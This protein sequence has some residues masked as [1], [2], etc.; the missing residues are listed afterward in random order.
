[1]KGSSYDT[2]IPYD[3]CR[4][5]EKIARRLHITTLIQQLA[6]TWCVRLDFTVQW[7]EILSKLVAI[8][9]WIEQAFFLEWPNGQKKKKK[10][11]TSKKKQE[12][13]L[14]S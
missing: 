4:E 7:C 1:L 8:Y 13:N 9:D 11:S 12:W 3:D 10:V 6:S 2:N 5:E 14:Q